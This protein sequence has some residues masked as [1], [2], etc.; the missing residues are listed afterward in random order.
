MN[1][2]GVHALVWV[3]DVHKAS[4]EQ[5]VANSKTAGFDLLELSLHDTTTL[6]VSHA[7]E[8]LAT[9]GL[10]VACSRGLAFDADVSS[11][12]PD[13]VAR[14]E[15]LLHDSLEV[16]NDLGA[17]T[18][19]GALYSALGKYDRP[20]TAKGRANAVGVLRDLAGAARGKHI[21]L[22]IEVVNRYESNVINTAREALDFIDDIDADNVFVHLDTYHMNI[23]ESDMAQPVLDCGDRLGY[24][25]VGE[26]HRGY[27][28]AG[29]I[30][31][32]AFFHALN[33]IGYRGGIT[34][35]SFS[36][37]VVMAGLSSDLAIW[38]NLWT[39]SM[40]L[41][42]QAREFLNAKLTAARHA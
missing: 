25:H 35:E 40:D 1:Q 11:D 19:C 22:G 38:R 12:D 30:D 21:D 29:A 8:V 37:E 15:T 17:K 42:C 10:E 9:H 28:G 33:R 34:F 13:T 20:V 32:T 24:V 23:E 18:L 7:R 16:A 4:I 26:N 5:A 27:L 39:D 14:G 41:A 36:S 31:F 6:D 3:G 2:L